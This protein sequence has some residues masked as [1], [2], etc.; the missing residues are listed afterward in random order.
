MP[1]PLSSPLRDAA[2]RYRYQELPLFG[3]P[4]T[5][6]RVREQDHAAI[7][8]SLLDA[9]VI[10]GR[11]WPSIPFPLPKSNCAFVHAKCGG[12]VSLGHPSEGSRSAQLKAGH[13][14]MRP[15]SHFAS[16][17]HA[18]PARQGPRAPQLAFVAEGRF[19]GMSPSNR[20]RCVASPRM[21]ARTQRNAAQPSI[22]QPRA[23]PAENAPDRRARSSS[24]RLE[25]AGAPAI[26]PI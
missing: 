11:C 19:S 24:R 10:R 16:F 17:L 6:R 8:Q 22:P 18:H 1:S 26:D 13:E 21:D 23:A 3:E 12:K 9:C 25:H 4:H 7:V 15:V 14:I 20:W 2:A 5:G